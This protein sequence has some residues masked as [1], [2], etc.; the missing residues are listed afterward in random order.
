ML[1]NSSGFFLFWTNGRILFIPFSFGEWEV[2]LHIQSN[3][4]SWYHQRRDFLS[5]QQ[6]SLLHFTENSLVNVWVQPICRNLIR[7]GMMDK[8]TIWHL[9]IHP[10]RTDPPI[11]YDELVINDCK[12]FYHW[13]ELGSLQEASRRVFSQPILVSTSVE[14]FG[15]IFSCCDDRSI[16]V[17]R[18]VSPFLRAPKIPVGSWCICLL[19]EKHSCFAYIKPLTSGS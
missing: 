2:L 19:L 9:S 4:I 12:I 8:L 7:D 16:D 11:D 13:S 14:Y 18:G 15:E 10:F 3:S 17:C 5:E 1:A 6:T